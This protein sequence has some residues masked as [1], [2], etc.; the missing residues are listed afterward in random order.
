MLLKEIYFCSMKLLLSSENESWTNEKICLEIWAYFVSASSYCNVT[1][2]WH[3]KIKCIATFL[4]SYLITSIFVWAYCKAIYILYILFIAYENCFKYL[5]K[6]MEEG[7]SSVLLF[8]IYFVHLCQNF[9][10][11]S[12]T[13]LHGPFSELIICGCCFHFLRGMS[14]MLRKLKSLYI[15]N[16]NKTKN[17]Q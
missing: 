15:S 3:F 4:I 16:T 2:H 11:K 17:V 13:S 7:F 8:I 12:C 5:P 14:R 1:D 9:T 6:V 10:M